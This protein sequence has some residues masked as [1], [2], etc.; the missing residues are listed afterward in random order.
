MTPADLLSTIETLIPL[1]ERKD[2]VSRA[3][4]T[5]RL[6]AAIAARTRISPW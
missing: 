4:E 5:N 6:N 1:L 2:H 3:A